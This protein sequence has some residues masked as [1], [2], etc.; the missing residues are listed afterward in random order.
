MVAHRLRR[1]Y[2]PIAGGISRGGAVRRVQIAVFAA[3]ALCAGLER[4]RAL[5]CVNGA[6]ASVVVA[7]VTERLE[8]VL[9]DKR[10]LRFA[11]LD[12]P[13]ADEGQAATTAQARSF[14]EAALVGRNAELALFAPKPD[15]WGR[16]VGDLTLDG[17][18]Q[19]LALIGTGYARVRPEFETR[20]CA[21]ER[22]G[23]EAKA[24]AAR[25]GLWTD[26][27]YQV[28]DATDLA[29]LRRR[30]GQFAVVEGTV[31][32]VGKTASRLY[33]D[34]GY[35]DGFSAVAPTSKAA[36]FAR[37]GIAL[38]ALAGTR[39]RVRGALDE[40]F[41]LRMELADPQQIERVEGVSGN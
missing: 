8:L 2:D 5:D 30:D 4:A 6:G 37:G 29:S 41:G 11:G 26:P 39:V 24:R 34:F 19:A 16:V 40:R 13:L 9:A 1:V 10:V 17:Q 36:E 7:E 35:R 31:R 32:R 14:L 12:M 23:E 21:T 27:A 20:G 38:A 22:L 25:R 15:R 18:S 28:I 33:L 3:L